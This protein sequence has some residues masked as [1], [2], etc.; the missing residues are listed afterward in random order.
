MLVIVAALL[1]FSDQRRLALF[2]VLGLFVPYLAL[3][4]PFRCGGYT[5][6]RRACRLIGN[7][8]LIGCKYH[9]FDRLGRVFG[10]DRDRAAARYPNPDRSVRGAAS[11]GLSGR[12]PAGEPTRPRGFDLLSLAVSV[13]SMIAGWLALWIGP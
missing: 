10:R 1:W 5:R 4:A 2:V 11:A 6:E 13:M 3:V 12:R 7:G 9:R 8:W